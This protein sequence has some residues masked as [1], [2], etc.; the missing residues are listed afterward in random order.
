M[1][2]ILLDLH[3]RDVNNNDQNGRKMHTIQF[4]DTHTHSQ[5]FEFTALFDYLLLTFLLY[6]VFVGDE[7][8]NHQKQSQHSEASSLKCFS[9]FAFRLN[10]SQLASLAEGYIWGYVNK[11]DN[12]LPFPLIQNLYLVLWSHKKPPYPS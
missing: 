6:L 8:D 11:F 1:N 4:T 3:P 5:V 10:T 2:S 12:F 9:I 7:L